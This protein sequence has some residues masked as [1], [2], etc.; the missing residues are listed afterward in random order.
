MGKARQ[1]D[2]PLKK[3]IREY[4]SENA[5]DLGQKKGQKICLEEEEG[6]THTTY[7]AK[8]GNSEYFITIDNSRTEESA[9]TLKTHFQKLKTLEEYGIAPRAYAFNDKYLK[10]ALEVNIKVPLMV[11]EKVQGTYLNHNGVLSNLEQLAYNADQLSEIPVEELR[12]KKGFEN[13]PST[14]K[15]HVSR[16]ISL[17]EGQLK[18]YRSMAEVNNN[19]ETKESADIFSEK[20]GEI[21]K[22]FETVDS[23]LN[24]THSRIAPNNIILGP[25]GKTK[26]V[27]WQDSGF[28]DTAHELAEFARLNDL[29]HVHQKEI[30]KHMKT[31][32]ESL[33]ERI[34]V[35]EE[36]VRIQDVL[37]SALSYHRSSPGTDNAKTHKNH[38][39]KGYS[40]L[41]NSLTSHNEKVSSALSTQDPRTLLEKITPEVKEPSMIKRIKDKASTIWDKI[42]NKDLILSGAAA[43]LLALYGWGYV[44]NRKPRVVETR[45]FEGFPI[46]IIDQKNRNYPGSDFI[47]QVLWDD[48]PSETRKDRNGKISAQVNKIPII[49]VAEKIADN[50]E[51]YQNI[52]KGSSWHPADYALSHLLKGYS[53]NGSKSVRDAYIRLYFGSLID[54][55]IQHL[56]DEVTKHNNKESEARAVLRQVWKSPVGLSTL[57][58]CANPGVKTPNYIRE[59]GKELIGCV[60]RKKGIKFDEDIIHLSDSERISVAESCFSERYPGKKLR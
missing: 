41:V 38:F 27:G 34:K 24:L 37:Q 33:E 42:P 32:D 45:H 14:S 58:S 28:T 46:E 44:E 12:N 52:E 5:E 1:E 19:D 48:P 8:V 35:Y 16:L 9:K 3:S 15:E 49:R 22:Y 26:L 7:S 6:R 36:L 17:T 57:I 40:G 59:I 55:E 31:A 25:D 47:D 20:I 30:F 60:K 43:G 4:L 39:C 50:W 54:H 53:K 11:T 18:D 2:T 51:D 23:P 21:K 56:I 29:P 13:E 10:T